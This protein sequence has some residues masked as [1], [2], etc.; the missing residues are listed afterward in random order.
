MTGSQLGKSVAMGGI[1]IKTAQEGLGQ[2]I[3]MATEDD[4]E[5]WWE[6]IFSPLWHGSPSLHSIIPPNNRGSI[7]LYKSELVYAGGRAEF[8]TAGSR[9]QMRGRPGIRLIGDEINT[10]T[11]RPD[12][13][14][15]VDNL[16]A[17]GYGALEGATKTFLASTPAI[18]GQCLIEY[19]YLDSSMG[20]WQPRCPHCSKLFALDL[21]DNVSL[22]ERTIHCSKCARLMTDHAMMTASR[23]GSMVHKYP[24]NRKRGYHV[25]GLCSMRQRTST[26]F[27]R[28]RPTG[29]KTFWTQTLGLPFES[30]PYGPWEPSDV[31]SLYKEA[32]PGWRPNVLTA[33]V[34]IRSLAIE[35][36]IVEWMGGAAGLAGRL[37]QT[38]R[39]DGRVDDEDTWRRFAQQLDRHRLD[40]VFIDRAYRP[41]IVQAMGRK[42]MRRLYSSRKLRFIKAEDRHR[43]NDG[44][45]LSSSG[46]N[47]SKPFCAELNSPVAKDWG[48]QLMREGNLTINGAG[49]D[50]K[51]LDVDL[52][53]HLSAEEVVMRST[54]IGVDRPAWVK[55]QGEPN[56]YWDCYI[57]AVCARVE[58]GLE[59]KPALPTLEDIM[60]VNRL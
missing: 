17:R 22:D 25:N 21:K 50:G 12:I 48:Y 57:Y 46:P 40:M 38:I 4:I 6:R 60:E 30:K 16:R 2:I 33:G 52:P 9:S 10:W 39:V 14:S 7:S 36:V 3:A 34:D 37:I 51:G 13:S 11:A 29:A 23:N 58:C 49:L 28:Y 19:E 1:I 47:T 5:S 59:D 27:A 31:M 18:S 42:Y 41:E 53:R 8:V 54:S 26:I 45:I 32:P 43:P 44:V 35:A 20:A 56:H 24:R 15:P 55:K